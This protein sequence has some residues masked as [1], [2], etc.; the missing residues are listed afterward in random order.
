MDSCLTIHIVIRIVPNMEYVI[1]T[2]NCQSELRL[3]KVGVS[4]SQ[5]ETAGRGWYAFI[6]RVH[7][8]ILIRIFDI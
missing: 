4:A 8:V 5:D 7:L 1:F 3:E 6:D 2:I